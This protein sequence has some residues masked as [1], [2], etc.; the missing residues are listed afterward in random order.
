MNS[1][2][3]DDLV[4]FHNLTNEG[5]AALQPHPTGQL[6]TDANSPWVRLA[7]IK[8]MF[9]FKWLDVF[10]TEQ[11]DS[12]CTVITNQY[13]NQIDVKPTL[14]RSQVSPLIMFLFY[15]AK[16]AKKANQKIQKKLR[17]IVGSRTGRPITISAPSQA[18]TATVSTISTASQAATVSAKA[19]AKI[20]NFNLKTTTVCRKAKKHHSI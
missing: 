20:Q 1:T 5:A 7:C 12:D 10:R 3:D 14:Y 6:N 2:C 8:N 17:G 13:K 15:K 16:K 9:L 18:A 4:R 11:R 19:A